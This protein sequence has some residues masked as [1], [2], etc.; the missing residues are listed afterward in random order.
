[1]GITCNITAAIWLLRRLQKKWI[2]KIRYFYVLYKPTKKGKR[3]HIWKF[4]VTMTKKGKNLLR[5]KGQLTMTKKAAYKSNE[6]QLKNHSLTFNHKTKSLL[7]T[8]SLISRSRMVYNTTASLRKIMW[9]LAN[10]QTDLDNYLRARKIPT[11]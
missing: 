4:Q 8:T 1:M 10:V 9:Y 11:T 6:M 7:P 5:W 2:W 3:F